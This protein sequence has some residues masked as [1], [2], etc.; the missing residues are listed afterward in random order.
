MIQFTVNEREFL[1]SKEECRLATSHDDV[2]HVKPVSYIFTDDI[3][4]IATDYETRTY[5]NLC[6][7][8]QVALVV[9]TY[10]HRAHKAVC[11]QGK[12]TIIEN[13][14]KFLEI[15]AKFHKKFEWVREEPWKEEEAPFLE[16]SPVRK[17]SWGLD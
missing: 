3:F 2:P 16:I 12:T 13:G 17:T 11:I 4:Y 1:A 14:D 15:Y 6:K 5:K 7:N 8:S 9:D 10:K